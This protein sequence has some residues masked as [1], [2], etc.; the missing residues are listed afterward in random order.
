MA[1]PPV[2]RDMLTEADERALSL[3]PEGWFS[4]DDLPYPA[5]KRADYRCDRLHKLGYL[6]YDVIG[7]HPHLQGRYKK[8]TLTRE[9]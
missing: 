6:E 7:T 5:I 4:T 9:E 1:I 8:K 3:I 2:N